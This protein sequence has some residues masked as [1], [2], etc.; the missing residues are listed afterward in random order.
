MEKVYQKI[1]D[2]RRGDCFKCTICTLLGLKYEEVPNYIEYG[3]A[4]F[5]MAQETFKQNGYKLTG[6]ELFN[7]K[8]M[9]LEN[10]TA[11]VYE[12]ITSYPP[13]TFQAIKPK[14]GINGLFLA[15]VYSPKYTNP[16]EHP[17]EHLHS[18][19]CDIDFNIVFDPQKDYENVVNYPYSKLIGYNGVRAIDVIIKID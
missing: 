9:Y 1:I 7:P 4:W 16:N 5:E 6:R 14:Y 17:I 19:L 18:V 8:T 2:P 3:D 13:C 12:D 15:S 11:N 10:P